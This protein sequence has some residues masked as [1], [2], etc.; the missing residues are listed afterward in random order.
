MRKT[1][2]ENR[3]NCRKIVAGLLATLTAFSAMAAISVSAAPSEADKADTVVDSTTQTTQADT[4]YFEQ[5]ETLAAKPKLKETIELNAAA[6]SA[7]QNPEKS[8]MT[9]GGKEGVLLNAENGWVEWTFDVASAGTVTAEVEY[10]PLTDRD[11]EIIVGVAI[12]GKYPYTDAKNISLNRV[13]ERVEYEGEDGRPFKKDVQDNEVRPEQEQKTVWT[14]MF[15][16][17]PQGL[18]KEPYMFYLSAGTHTLRFSVD[19]ASAVIGKIKLYNESIISYKDYYE[20]Y[21]SKK[22]TGNE[23]TYLQA[24]LSYRTSS[25]SIYPTYDKLDPATVP[26]N[27]KSTVL[28]TIGA[29]NWAAV[30]SYISWKANVPEAGMYKISFRARQNVNSGMISYRN[31]YINGKIPFAEAKNIPFEYSQNWK[32]YTWGEDSEQ[33]VYLEPGDVI[34]LTCSTGDTSEVLRNVQS[35]VTDLNSLYREVIAITSVNPDVYQD[36]NLEKRIP[37]L[38]SNLNEIAELLVGTEKKLAEI[39]GSDGSMASSIGF[40][41]EKVEYF[42]KKPYEISEKLSTFKNAAETLGSLILSLSGQPLEIDYIAFVPEKAEEPSGKVGFFQSLSYG[43]KQFIYSFINDYSSMSNLGDTEKT[44]VNVWVATGRDQAQVIN[45]LITSDFSVKTGIPVELNM[46]TDVASTLIKAALAG[47]GPD[48]ALMVGQQEPVELAARGALVDLTD[49]IDEDVYNGVHKS[50][51]VPLKYQNRIYAMPESQAFQVTFYRTDIFEELGLKVPNT[52]DEVYDVLSV[53][54]SKNL[55]VGMAEINTAAMGVSA[56]LYIFNSLMYQNGQTNYYTEDLSKT[57]FDTEIAY[58]AFTKWSE[59]YTDYGLD[60]SIDFYSRFRSGEAPYGFS[61]FTFYTQLQQAAP[62]IRGLWAMAKFPGTVQEDGSVSRAQ[63]G[64][65]TTC[66]MLKAAKDKGVADDA[67]E[68]MKWW[69]SAETQTSYSA[70]VEV[71]L[72]IAGR[73]SPANLEAFANV[74]WSKDDYEL[75]ESHR[76]FIINQPTVIGNYSVNRDLTS[77]MRDVVADVSRPRRALL[78]YNTDINE[79]IARKRREFGLED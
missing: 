55:T 48:V 11:G 59:F 75:I 54:Q 41:R 56:S 17:D 72:G 33:L 71:A 68:F 36:Y 79:E 67:Y 4:S 77:A 78:L 47:K 65:V 52:W 38:E 35:A 44:P 63:D 69:I 12:D 6:K 13:W 39:L 23:V 28:N 70:D 24:E 45:N 73:Y 31:L 57:L 40:A 2:S 7:V 34:T 51:W 14:K 64:A 76:K 66:V 22:A 25:S 16:S 61:G 60:R 37:H 49:Y 8:V 58:D 10:A 9:V 53:L 46:V 15:L 21:S 3:F 27:P 20:K 43:F 30:G 29:S 19:D 18:Y 50:A 26:N 5:Y 62:E 1:F 74:D 42:A 32:M